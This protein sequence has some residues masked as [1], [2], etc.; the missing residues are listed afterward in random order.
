KLALYSYREKMPEHELREKITAL[1]L[2]SRIQD[3]EELW[4]RF[5]AERS[6][7]QRIGIA[8]GDKL[9]GAGM[10]SLRFIGLDDMDFAV[11]L[12]RVID[13]YGIESDL[14]AIFTVI[15]AASEVG[16]SQLMTNR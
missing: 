14:A 1:N 12:A 15:A 2:P 11:L 5:L 10:E 4:R 9:T 8:S 6:R 7:L 3:N 13:H 16:F